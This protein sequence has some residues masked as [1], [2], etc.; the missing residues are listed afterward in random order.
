MVTCISSFR[1]LGCKTKG[2]F[3]I[4]LASVLSVLLLLS[5]C[6]NAS[7]PPGTDTPSPGIDTPSPTPASCLVGIWEMKSPETFLR[8]SLPPGAFDL[9]TLKYVD[10]GGGIAYRFDNQGVLTMEAVNF[11]GRF[12]VKLPQALAPLELKMNGFASGKYTFD[13]EV[14][15]VEETLTSDID[16][17]AIFD[18]ESM[19]DDARVNQ[20]APL[21]M[22]PYNAARVECSPEKLTLDVLNFPGVQE[23]I[24]FKRLR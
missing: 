11:F 15:R 17:S 16:Y 3:V 14:V 21:F 9:E 22:E 20:F 13:E 6:S 24:E 18:G 5:A 23:R 7:P 4:S 10:S 12:D 19:M 2:R 1:L 8:L